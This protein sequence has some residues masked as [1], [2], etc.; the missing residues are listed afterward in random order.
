M[1]TY[2]RRRIA[3]S[4]DDISAQERIDDNSRQISRGLYHYEQQQE[5]LTET[6][7]ERVDTVPVETY[8]NYI[9]FLSAI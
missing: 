4:H 7:R 1:R 6:Q 9:Y 2:V 5:L 3:T 8:Q